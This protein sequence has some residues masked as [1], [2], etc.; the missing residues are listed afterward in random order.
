MCDKW[1]RGIAASRLYTPE[2]VE[3]HSRN[4]TT[5]LKLSHSSI[6][7][8]RYE[9]GQYF[10][11]NIPDISLNEW[12]PFTATAIL[13]DGIVFCIKRMN[14]KRQSQKGTWTQR[15][16]DRA[17][18]W[19][20]TPLGMRLSG[21]FGHTDFTSYEKLLLIAG[22][23][24]ITPMIAIFAHLKK[25][26]L[27]GRE[28]G[29][30]KTVQLIWMS[31]SVGEFRLFEEIFSL[32]AEDGR[33]ATAAMRLSLVIHEEHREGE[34]QGNDRMKATNEAGTFEQGLKNDV[35]SLHL[36]E[37]SV[38]S[39]SA[40]HCEASPSRPLNA[41]PF[42]SSNLDKSINHLSQ[43]FETEQVRPLPEGSLELSPPSLCANESSS[44]DGGAN[45]EAT[46]RPLDFLTNY[47]PSGLSPDLANANEFK[48]QAER[49]SSKACPRADTVRKDSRR[50]SVASFGSAESFSLQCAF[51]LGL[52]CTRRDSFVSLT[53]PESVD[54][55][56]LF[57]KSGRC[58]LKS[59]FEAMSLRGHSS[60]AA[61]CG[62]PSL[63]LDVSEH[64]ANM[65][66]DFHTEQFLF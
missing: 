14:N 4:E 23:I 64:A 46:V 11:L 21:P 29:K 55:V 62:P 48:V 17:Q 35:N 1:S 27:L 54:Y 24:G 3:W 33:K 7:H 39:P 57:I 63:M 16:A 49:K 38:P 6:S 36:K 58:N 34:E 60:L 42:D 51:D 47:S 50:L 37:S 40:Q 22:G 59:I 25:Q 30:L 18:S 9:P 41:S 65:G 61:V 53:D 28:L 26:Q 20:S 32:L 56:K 5:L 66:C 10:F 52:Y 43:Q 12:H 19:S 45:A 15:L 13:D 8:L 2:L 44:G 31:R